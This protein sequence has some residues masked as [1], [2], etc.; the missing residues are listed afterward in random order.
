MLLW[1]A[2]ATPTLRSGGRFPMPEH[3]PDFIYRSPK[4]VA[5]HLNDHVGRLWLGS[6]EVNLQPGDLTLTPAQMPSRY[7]LAG[8]S[9]HL[10]VHFNALPPGRAPLRLPLHW[11]TGPYER[12]VRDRLQEAIDLRR[13]GDGNGPAA[14]LA[15]RAAGVSLQG[16]LLW[17]AVIVGSESHASA[18]AP[19]RVDAVVTELRRHLDEH[20]RDP[21][22]V[23]ALARKVGVS[24]NYLA[25]QFQVR[26]GTTLKRYVLGRRI[27]LARHLL[28]V[29]RLPIKAVAIE[30]GLGNP[31]YFHRQFRLIT[32]RSPSQERDL[33]T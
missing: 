30:A 12:M 3:N 29:T 4:T 9:Y 16:L 24:Q 19:S 20:Y 18:A 10:C 33:V 26:H 6:R 8:P 5:L 27:E 25:R 17:V 13:R 14:A 11:R 7:D 2:Q 15:R 28:A 22:D 32:G 1:P 31:Q 21:L 23:S